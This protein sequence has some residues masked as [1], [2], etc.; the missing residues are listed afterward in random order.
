MYTKVFSIWTRIFGLIV[1]YYLTAL[2][3]RTWKHYVLSQVMNL[4]Q[5]KFKYMIVDI[6]ERQKA[7]EAS[8]QALVND[9]TSKFAE[10]ENMKSEISIVLSSNVNDI[11]LSFLELFDT[12]LFKYADGWINSWSSSG[13]SSVNTGW[14]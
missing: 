2:L 6:Q 12:L 14:P 13:F 4:A 11:K 7:L 5:S 10:D 9:L 1:R 8:S 3:I